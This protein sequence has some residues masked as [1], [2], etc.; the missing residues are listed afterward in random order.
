LKEN[1]N[2]NRSQIKRQIWKGIN[3]RQRNRLKRNSTTKRYRTKGR[4]K[5][6]R[7]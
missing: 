7:T 4:R 6:W 3:K 2:K 5:K 1:E